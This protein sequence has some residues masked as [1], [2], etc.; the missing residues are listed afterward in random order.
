MRKKIFSTVVLLVINIILVSG[1]LIAIPLYI[2]SNQNKQRA[3]SDLSAVYAT[4]N[5]SDS[6]K[7]YFNQQFSRLLDKK[8]Y[9]ASRGGGHSPEEI[10]DFLAASDSA[11]TDYQLL[12]EDDG[13]Y[14]RGVTISRGS[15]IPVAYKRS[16]YY[17][18]VVRAYNNALLGVTDDSAPAVSAAF[19]NAVDSLGCVAFY[20]AIEVKDGG[21][22]RNGLLMAVMPIK[23]LFGSGLLPVVLYDSAGGA[24]I[25]EEGQYIVSTD[26]FRS[27][28]L[29][30]HLISAFNMSYPQAAA[31]REEIFSRPI[32][33]VKLTD[34][35]SESYLFCYSEITGM[36]GWRYISKIPESS[37]TA[38]NIDL[39]FTIIII[40]FV[41]LLGLFNGGYM[42]AL[43]KDLKKSLEDVRLAKEAAEAANAAKS[44]F[45][46]RM[47]HEIRT[48]LNAVNGYMIIARKNVG[49]DKKVLDCLNKTEV[50]S[51]HLL[52]VINDILDVSAIESGKLKITAECFDLQD[53]ITAISSMFYTMAAAKRVDFRVRFACQIP[54]RIIGD[55][56]HINQILIN[57]LNNAVKFTP[58]GG[59][60]TLELSHKSENENSEV[61]IRVMDSGI[62]M[63]QEFIEH[64]WEPFEQ[65]DSSIS[66]RYGGTGL[67]LTI[68]KNLVDLMEG[69]IEITST[70][71]S[72]SVFK[73]TLPLKAAPEEAPLK[74]GEFE[75]Y[76]ALILP[77]EE[78]QADYFVKLLEDMGI[79]CETAQIPEQFDNK[80]AKKPFARKFDFCFADIDIFSEVKPGGAGMPQDFGAIKEIREDL[81]GS[82]AF[83]ICAYDHSDIEA[84]AM[85]AGAQGFAG[86]PIFPPALRELI[87]GL[88]GEVPADNRE[89]IGGGEDALLEG[90]HLLLAEDNETNME[91]A[92][93]LLEMAGATVDTAFNGE[94][95]LEKFAASPP[96]SYKAVLMDIQMPVMD[97]YTAAEAIRRCSNPEGKTIP[98]IAMSANAFESDIRKALEAGMNDYMTKPIDDKTLY[99]MLRKYL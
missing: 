4:M 37:L 76:S 81:C 62:G 63:S 82:A 27:V 35:R 26:E 74:G 8:K 34:S 36:S 43:N 61:T 52:N 95:A 15:I 57:L 54:Q 19:S 3:Q 79:K 30:E 16:S 12:I 14:I 6:V 44:S 88:T 70:L 49:N 78:E 21:A 17:S 67:G 24:I 10:L 73:V 11:Q 23:E 45:L 98:I 99:E 87:A 56:M 25:D 91:I 33:S 93:D 86:K 20:T 7:V 47:S 42:L 46:S 39:L 96:G 2:N 50:S 68:T 58:E 97:G 65:A 28:S 71:G 80:A 13:E 22:L 32:G 64:I 9:L 89:S 85:E 51:K 55:E 69:N 94:Q 1:M 29:F 48:P 59:R 84:K 66:R 38:D 72:G 75:G 40:A 53:L 5:V 31:L 18:S 90:M 77:G 41:L 83:I 60:V 92:T